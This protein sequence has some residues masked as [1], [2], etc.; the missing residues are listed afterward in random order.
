MVLLVCSSDACS[1][2]KIFLCFLITYIYSTI[3]TGY[4][5]NVNYC[6]L[7]FGRRHWTYCKF[8]PVFI[9]LWR[10]FYSF[11]SIFVLVFVF[12]SFW[13]IEL[14]KFVRRWNY[15]VKRWSA[16]KSH[17]LANWNSWCAIMH[18][19]H[20]W[21]FIVILHTI[22]ANFDVDVNLLLKI[23]NMKFCDAG[24][25]DVSSSGVFFCHF[26]QWKRIFW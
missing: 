17:T 16:K 9:S 13:Q 14:G 23:C 5:I 1:V 22:R 18:S 26:V 7:F 15:M 20:V 25:T 19:Y 4:R 11:S 21:F 10:C 12:L 6:S 3:F 24:K 2:F 8:M